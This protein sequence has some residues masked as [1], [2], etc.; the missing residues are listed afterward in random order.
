MRIAELLDRAR[1]ASLGGRREEARDLLLDVLALEPGQ[2]EAWLR[3]A[4]LAASPERAALYYQR[5]AAIDPRSLRAQKGLA[6]AQGRLQP[7]LERPEEAPSLAHSGGKE[8]TF[9]GLVPSGRAALP[10]GVP[11]FVDQG[12]APFSLGPGKTPNLGKARLGAGRG[13]EVGARGDDGPSG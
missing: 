2:L 13:D 9:P 4:E 10:P 6:E 11:I 7:P 1:A 3:L 5:A 12:L 8:E